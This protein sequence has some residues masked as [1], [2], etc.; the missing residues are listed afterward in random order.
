MFDWL[1]KKG[2]G[3]R[4]KGTLPLFFQALRADQLK[5]DLSF[6]ATM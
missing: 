3:R 4:E 1:L 6:S 2:K 5:F